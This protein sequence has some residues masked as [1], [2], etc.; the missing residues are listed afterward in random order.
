MSR[1]RRVKGHFPRPAILLAGILAL[2]MTTGG[3]VYV[4]TRGLL[5]GGPGPLEETLLF[6]KG[7]TKV[8]CLEI[9]GLIS[10]KE[11][12]RPFH[13][14]VEPSLVASVKEQLD[15]AA[16]DRRV[17]GLLLTINSPGGTVTASDT[18]YNEIKTFKE[19]HHVKVAA[20]LTGTAT[21]GAYYVAQAADRIVAHPTVVTGS[22]GVILLNIN[23]NGLM[24]KI[25]VRDATVKSGPY[26]DLGSPLRKP[27]K[28]EREILQGVVD[29]LQARFVHVVEEN[30]PGLRT[31]GSPVWGDGR[32]FTARQAA[33]IGLVDQV[34]Y[35]AD[36]VA[37]LRTAMGTS[38]IRVI[39]YK[40]QGEYVPNV[41]A[42]G[43]P[44]GIHSEVNLVK[45]DLDG[46]LADSGPAFMYLWRPGL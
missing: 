11:R 38:G 13:L 41:Y 34:G 9:Q 46:L 37:W 16:R 40:R 24:E 44:A 10:E 8:L 15:K 36:A 21:S 7:K 22:I 26:K 4:S 28:G 32:I 23:L 31:D 35:V 30:R 39:R 42:Y 27:V 20:L 14:R 18:I 6:G 5:G 33:S 1:R 45:L 29:E 12:A 19:T 2:A 25:G 3:C 43:G 17:R